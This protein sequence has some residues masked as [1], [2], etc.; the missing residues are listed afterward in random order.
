MKRQADTEQPAEI[1]VDVIAAC[2]DSGVTSAEIVE[3]V[4][5]LSVLQMLHRL[6]CF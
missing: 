4:G 2:R 6:T 1:G 5:W 3:L